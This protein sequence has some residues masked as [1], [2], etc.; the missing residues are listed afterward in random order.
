MDM[1]DE[2]LVEE[3]VAVVSYR[4]I[5]L[6]VGM[7]PLSLS[8]MSQG[9]QVIF[10]II[11]LENGERVFEWFDAKASYDDVANFLNARRKAKNQPQYKWDQYELVNITTDPKGTHVMLQESGKR[12]QK[13][14]KLA[15]NNCN[16]KLIIAVREKASTKAKESSSTTAER[17]PGSGGKKSKG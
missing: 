8:E 16:G 15:K 1:L 2:V 10:V 14:E 3:T 7:G 9:Q 4:P 11:I 17:T 6:T 13:S 12:N 5:Q